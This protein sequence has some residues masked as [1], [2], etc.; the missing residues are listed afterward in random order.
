MNKALAEILLNHVDWVCAQQDRFPNIVFI[1]FLRQAEEHFGKNEVGNLQEIELQLCIRIWQ[2]KQ[3]ECIEAGRE[4]VRIFQ[5]ISERPEMALI[6]E[7]L[8]KSIGGKPLMK[9]LLEKRGNKPGEKNVYVSILLNVE[10]QR[11]LEF[12]LFTLP[13]ENAQWHLKWLLDFAGIEFGKE[14][15]SILV[16]LVRYIV[17]NVTPHNDIIHSNILQ[18]HKMIGML[19]T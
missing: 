8:S 17:V 12:M 1:K 16:D 2:S 9:H 4:L 13:E 3:V 18:R 6:K 7:E 15:E 14:S 10:V 5:N 19:I 11:R